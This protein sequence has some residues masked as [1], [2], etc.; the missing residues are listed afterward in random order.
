VPT[1]VS[2]GSAIYSALKR[3]VHNPKATIGIIG[4]KAF[5]LLALSFARAMKYE[6]SVI[7]DL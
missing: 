3:H 2:D 6:V 7:G 1:L 4:S 5:G